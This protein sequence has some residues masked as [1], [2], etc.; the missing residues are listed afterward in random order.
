MTP[1]RPFARRINGCEPYA[2]G[3][4][5]AAALSAGNKKIQASK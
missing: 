1:G 5:M 3:S 2:R 4:A